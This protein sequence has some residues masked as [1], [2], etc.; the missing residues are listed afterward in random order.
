MNNTRMFDRMFW[1]IPTDVSKGTSAFEVLLFVHN[2]T[3]M[4]IS[5]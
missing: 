2:G 3:G 5:P 1:K 4:L